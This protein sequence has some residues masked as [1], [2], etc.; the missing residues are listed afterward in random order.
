ML[1]SE[2]RSVNTWLQQSI[3]IPNW[4]V[5]GLIAVYGANEELTLGRISKR[6]H[7]FQ[8]VLLVVSNT[9]LRTLV[10]RGNF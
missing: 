2:I 7:L 1:G 3:A 4:G 8:V 5:D 10:L 9:M 6:R